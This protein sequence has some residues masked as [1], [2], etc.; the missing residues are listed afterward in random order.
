MASEERPTFYLYSIGHPPDQLSLGHLVLKDYANPL[1]ARNIRAPEITED[2]IREWADITPANCAFETASEDNFAVGLQVPV[3][4]EVSVRFSG[5][6]NKVI[7][8]RVGRRVMLKDSSKFFEDVV[9]KNEDVRAKLAMWCTVA[10]SR[11]VL[12]KALLGLRR[13]QIWLLTGFYE[14]EGASLSQLHHREPAVELGIGAELVTALSGVPVGGSVGMGGSRLVRQRVEMP[15]AR[16]WAAQWQRLDAEWIRQSGSQDAV[17]LTQVQLLPDMT[18]SKGVMLG[19]PEQESGKIVA[20]GFTLGSLGS[21]DDIVEEDKEYAE[22]F[23][24]AERRLS[25]QRAF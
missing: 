3:A 17:A 25:R 9:A 2:Q 12:H 13:P 23:A 10:S 1:L 11:Y 22:A 18:F 5:T 4:G 21:R 7:T 8:A 24:E 6:K 15:E 19:S 20:A 14:F 16:I